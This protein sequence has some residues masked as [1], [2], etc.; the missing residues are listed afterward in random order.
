MG[1]HI[2]HITRLCIIIV[3][4]LASSFEYDDAA[5]TE[6]R[7]HLKGKS[8][9]ADMNQNKDM[10]EY[11]QTEGG[12]S[13]INHI[14]VASESQQNDETAERYNS[15]AESHSSNIFDEE[16]PKMLNEPNDTIIHEPR[17]YDKAENVTPTSTHNEDE[18]KMYNGTESKQNNLFDSSLSKISSE[19][20]DDSLTISSAATLNDEQTLHDTMEND[21]NKRI[22][23]GLIF[24]CVGLVAATIAFI[25][26]KSRQSRVEQAFEVYRASIST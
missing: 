12:L 13:A 14:E 15:N 21:T 7:R 3:V 5:V 25:L 24:S 22:Q 8:S 18:S 19:S 1:K 20:T 4:S 26:V 23:N 17:L 10:S 6:K 16:F 11:T 2:I 9:K